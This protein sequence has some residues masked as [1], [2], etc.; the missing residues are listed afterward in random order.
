MEAL[1]SE[2][3]INAK[4]KEK[5]EALVLVKHKLKDTHQL[6]KASGERTLVEIIEDTRSG[7]PAK[8]EI[9][10]KVCLTHYFYRL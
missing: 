9:D 10:S 5:S 3:K 6:V 4:D 7:K 2:T 8:S 1:K